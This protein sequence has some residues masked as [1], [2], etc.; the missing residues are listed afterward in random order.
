M[1][2]RAPTSAPASR[3]GTA[4]RPGP[5]RELALPCFLYGPER[6]LPEVRRQAFGRLAPDTG[7][8]RPHPSAGACAVGARPV[9]VAYNLWLDHRRTSPWPGPSPAAIRGPAVRA[10]GLA[11]AERHPGVVQPVDPWWSGPARG[12]RRRGPAGRAT[13]APR[14]PGPSS[15]AWCPAAVVEAVPVG[16]G[17]TSPLDLGPGDARIEARLAETRLAR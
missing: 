11:V 17:R 8:P 13:P 3:P 12:L 7:P 2:A 14:W 6:T 10:L 1:Q 5:A 15:W 9:L 16:A 4:S